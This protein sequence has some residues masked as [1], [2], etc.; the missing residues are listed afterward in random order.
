MALQRSNR[1][2]SPFRDRQIEKHTV[3]TQIFTDRA[4][5]PPTRCAQTHA[6]QGK[7]KRNQLKIRLGVTSIRSAK[8]KTFY[9]LFVYKS[10]IIRHFSGRRD[11]RLKRIPF[12]YAALKALYGREDREKTFFSHGLKVRS[13]GVSLAKIYYRELK[14]YPQFLIIYSPDKMVHNPK[15]ISLVHGSL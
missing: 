8:L 11:N 12:V 10:S 13:Y 1:R 14:L 5:V 2:I 6:F 15:K 7:S 3:S 9:V 4:N